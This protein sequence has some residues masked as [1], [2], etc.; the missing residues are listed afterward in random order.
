ME[1]I[2]IIG[3]SGR[4]PG[5]R[6]IEALWENLCSGAESVSVFS[7]E[8][9]AA[10]GV[11][12]SVRGQPH[13]VPA[14]GVLD[15]VDQFDASFFGLA[16][17]EAATMDP[18]QRLFLECA[19]EVLE[20][21]GHGA[22]ASDNRIG[23]F[24][25]VSM[26]TYLL[27]NLYGHPELLAGAAGY[28]AALGNDKDFVAT[29]VAYKL[30]LR[31]PSLTVQT[32]CSTSLVAVHVA[33][34][35]LISY[36]CD[37]ALAG[38]ACVQ[39]PQASGYVYEPEGILSPDGHC[40]AFDARAQGTVSGNGVGVV[41][42]KRLSDALNDGDTVY[43]V[44][45]GSA[46]NNDG[47]LK[48]GFTAP[49]VDGQTEAITE[50]LAMADVEPSSISY[51]EAHGTAT[52][53]GDPIELSALKRA[54]RSASRATCALGSV[55]SNLGH[56]DAAA[57]VT[58]LIKTALALHHRKLP[59][60][61]HY[62]A[63]NPQLGL[64]DSPFYV[65]AS[66]KD[67]QPP[68][69][70]PRRAGVSAFGIGGTNAHV[71][72]EEAPAREVPAST[73][74]PQVLV[75][76]AKT[77]S[78]L[79]RATAQ[80]ATHLQ[81]H[82][83]LPL[84]DV[85]FT[86][87][88]GRR[89]L[90]HRRFLIAS[91]ALQAAQLLQDSQQ[92]PPAFV[93]GFDDS[94]ERPVVFM[95][96][97][98]GAQY[99]LMGQSLY[100]SLPLFRDTVDR[101]ASLL[102]PLLGQDVRAVLYPPT[103][104]ADASAALLRQPRLG[105]PALFVT[106]YALAQQW[107]AWG[108]KPQAL[109]GHSLGEYV[110]A[111]LAGVFS[112][113][114]A[115]ALVCLRG[116]LFEQLPPGAMLSVALS[117]ADV[118]P[119]L[120][121]SLSLAA[122]NAPSLCVVSGPTFA[123]AALA[124]RL[125]ESSVE[126]REIAIDVAAHS[127]LVEP[128]LA[129]FTR[130]LSS[131]SLHAPKLPFLSNVTGTWITAQEAT[132]PDYWAR[133]L[134]QTVRFASGVETALASLGSPLF[135]EVG[136]GQTLTRL[137]HLSTRAH[138]HALVL[139][140]MR[141][142]QEEADDVRVLLASL[143]KAWLSGVPLSW[144]AVHAAPPRR[145]LLP[146]YPY[147][148]QRFWVE[149][150]RAS[151]SSLA[152][153][154]RKQPHVADWFY[155]PSWKRSLPPRAS[156]SAPRRCL[157]FLDALDLAS[158]LVSRLE[159]LGHS[160]FTVSPGSEYRRE[161]SHGFVIDPRSSTG[162]ARLLGDLSTAQSLPDLILHGW[163]LTAP[164]APGSDALER[165]LDLGFYSLLFLT[166]ALGKQHLTESLR[167]VTLANGTQEVTGHEPLNAA[168]AAVLGLCNV[169]PQEH[170][171][172]SC[173]SIDVEPP[174]DAAGTAA[175]AARL[176]KEVLADMKDAA[177]A[178]RGTHR[179][180]QTFEQVPQ[181]PTTE[182]ALPLRQRGTYLI[183]GGLGKIG[184]ELARHLARTVQARLVLLGRTGVPTREEGARMLADGTADETTRERLRAL[185]ELE[186]LGAEV[187]VLR[188]DVADAAQVSAAL[189]AATARFGPLHGVIHAAGTT[190]DKAVRLIDEALPTDCDWH[191]APKVRGLQV[192]ASL[193]EGRDLD[194][195]I[196]CSS[197]ASV[198]GGLGYA[199]YASANRF[200]DVFA[201]AHGRTSAF[202][203]ISVNWEGWRTDANPARGNALGATLQ[204]LTLTPAEGVKAFEHLLS[205]E[206][207]AHVLMSTGS[208]QAR[209]DRWTRFQEDGA[210]PGDTASRANLAHVRPQ[211]RTEYVAPRGELEQTIAD[212]WQMLL[213]I[214]R[215]G[216]H[217]NFF[218]L[219]GHSLLAT[220]LTT[221]LK[222]T[223][224]VELPLRRLLASPTVASIADVV[225]QAQAEQVDDDT[226][227]QMLADL[228]AMSTEDTA[229]LLAESEAL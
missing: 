108:L 115:L 76:S 201:Q 32:A 28:Q 103:S 13:Y 224:K 82:P 33:C 10:A 46:I 105:L 197:L 54:F 44:I 86:L 123:I 118:L 17:R 67:W 11:D 159:A 109:I 80:L 131:L 96:P 149:P 75:L 183:T 95:F 66:L 73:N 40:R 121:D 89:L 221:R 79:E 45:R 25:G 153:P 120:G 132:R 97:G 85:A 135:L 180:V 68:A 181:R 185:D 106:S 20:R 151:L 81:A 116:R 223:F 152:D 92:Q 229:D 205:L 19:A 102:L 111:C 204:E 172:I 127:S 98:G 60:S 51:V 58:G 211:L 31:G 165:D 117:E 65:N 210:A 143:G 194:F 154:L 144:D 110:A 9:L 125:R 163:G 7:D 71:I 26:N 157:V 182:A 191:F 158:S 93:S 114:D 100:A 50:A 129:E 119:L 193:L 35:N 134:R 70:V 166:Q 69:G 189:D 38:G 34:Q 177:V 199:A 176:V 88:V 207:V 52:P 104:S 24:A 227:A 133:H 222:A 226:L 188:A 1:T 55:K 56:L 186:S 219:G 47:S 8:E 30:G 171:N 22:P 206:P 101:C 195:C 136:P 113:Q 170:Q 48:P 49:S 37:M 202:P 3:M 4:F 16:P 228:E 208:L 27:H 164:D 14:R 218:E 174:T 90:P 200:M 145:V 155:L 215:V 141:H 175:L 42:L 139:S 214:D 6:S 150:G 61:L 74:A 203:W 162:Y 192:L 91:D 41:L 15:D 147:E 112:L 2:A 21:A 142:P 94:D 53:M 160:V 62:S 43:A 168:K 146:T 39:V 12:A 179:W 178:Y 124:A 29:R 23:V 77:A 36:R 209:L 217:D 187:L 140:S 126:H 213:G 225:L 5:A 63:P 190:G 138:S 196:L 64:E 169:I 156:A 212:M 107:L 122:V 72:L 128:L 173:R 184:L 78:A 57:G 220:Q 137:A 161:G 83:E 84:A 148:R 87:Q 198:L 216:I 18:Q 59:P 167:I 99:V 130:V